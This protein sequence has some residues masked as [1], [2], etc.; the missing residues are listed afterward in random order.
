MENLHFRSLPVIQCPSIP[1]EGTLA[2]SKTLETVYKPIVPPKP[3][4]MI[5]L[6]T[7]EEIRNRYKPSVLSPLR[8]RTS[9]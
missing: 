7:I 6:P 5:H 1:S 4:L 3:Q 8:K 2:N 9:L